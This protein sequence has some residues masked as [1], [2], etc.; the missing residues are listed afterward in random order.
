MIESARA[1]ADKLVEKATNPIAK[2]AA[3]AAADKL[4]A[5]AERKAAQMIEQARNK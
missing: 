2:V 4:I 3:R 5:E 1:E